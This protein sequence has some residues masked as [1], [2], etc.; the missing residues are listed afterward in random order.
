ML[1]IPDFT[2]CSGSITAL[3]PIKGCQPHWITFS[4][5]HGS[6]HGLGDD[7]ALLDVDVVT[8]LTVRHVVGG[9]VLPTV[10]RSPGDE[11]EGEDWPC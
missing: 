1:I 4:Y 5:F 3:Q 7:V 2:S 8:H 6:H 9:T 10:P 11:E